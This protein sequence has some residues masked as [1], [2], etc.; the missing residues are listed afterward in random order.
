MAQGDEVDVMNGIE[1]ERDR[2]MTLLRFLVTVENW[3]KD[4][5]PRAKPYFEADAVRWM[6]D[7]GSRHLAFHPQRFD[8]VMKA[9]GS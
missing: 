9:Q 2:G 8:V 1:V 5:D 7:E 3:A 4:N 6:D